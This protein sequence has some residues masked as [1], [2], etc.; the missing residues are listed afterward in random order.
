MDINFKDIII[1]DNSE[2]YDDKWVEYNTEFIEDDRYNVYRGMG[3]YSL[4]KLLI[5]E[6]VN[7]EINSI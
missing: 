1:N 4:I 3:E 2:L 7:L 6:E 5:K